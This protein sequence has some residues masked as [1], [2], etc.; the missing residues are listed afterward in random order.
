M[1]AVILS[2]VSTK[3]QEE[4]HSIGAQKQRLADYCIRRNLSVIKTFEIIESS[5]RGERKAFLAMVD[6]AKSQK[7]TIAIV[8]DAVDRF[9]RSFKESVM[10]DELIRKE[11]IELHFYRENMIIGKNASSSDILRWDFSVMGAKSYVLNLSEN[12]RRSLE[13]KR[14]NGEWGGK[15]PLGYLNIRDNSNKSVIIQDPLRAP[16]I[17]KLFEEY[18]RGG[19]S[20][21]GDLVDQARKWGLTNKTKKGGYLSGSQIHHILKNPF[22]HGEMPIKGKLYSHNYLPLIDKMLFDRCKSLRTGTRRQEQPRFTEKPFVFRGLI[23]CAISGKVVVSDIKKEKH[24]YLICRDPDSPEKKVFVRQRDVEAQIEEL[25]RSFY[26]APNDLETLTKYLKQTNEAASRFH[27]DTVAELR[28]KCDQIQNKLTMLLDMRLG[29]SITE[30]EYDAKAAELKSSHIELRIQI[31]QHQEGQDEFQTT[32]ENL[33]NIATQSY[34]IYTSSNV[35]QKRALVSFVFSNLHMRGK[36]LEYSMRS[37]FDL[38]MN[39]ADCPS[40]L[41]D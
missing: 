39:H 14:R 12:V 13:F 28:K 3:E 41:G 37:P 29:S 38:M 22:Y 5:T 2:R 17:R 34:K 4:G 26:I 11:A 21:R 27:K 15:A 32:L 10:I 20:I 25:F 7:E 31:E 18:G 30:Q 40:W 16:L 1:K 36:K 24:V 35:E 23:R 8:A 9:Q 33:I 6:F 19:S